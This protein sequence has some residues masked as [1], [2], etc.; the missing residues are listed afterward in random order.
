MTRPYEKNHTI[1]SVQFSSEARYYFCWLTMGFAKKNAREG[2][3]FLLYPSYAAEL[4]T[5]ASVS[6][7]LR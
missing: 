1:P 2:A 7:S 5:G 3:L 6:S 4:C